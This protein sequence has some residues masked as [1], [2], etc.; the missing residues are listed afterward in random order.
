MADSLRDLFI[1]SVLR[2]PVLP[3][4]ATYPGDAFVVVGEDGRETVYA[5]DGTKWTTNVAVFPIEVVNKK[6]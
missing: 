2:G 6:S 1:R 4:R 5:W 3:E